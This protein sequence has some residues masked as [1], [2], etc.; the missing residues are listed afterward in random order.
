MKIRKS[1]A[2]LALAGSALFVATA[3]SSED[4]DEATSK[5]STAV[6]SAASEVSTAAGDAIDEVTGLSDSK[7]QDI[8]RKAVDPATPADEIDTVVDTSDPATKAAVIAFAKGSSAAGY[9]PEVYTVKD[10]S[11]DGDK[12][13]VATVSVASPHAPAPVDIKLTYVD[14]DGGW[15]LSA[16]AVTQL[17]GMAT[18][19]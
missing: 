11:K 13:A 7:A 8:L 4:V 15:K 19:H 16:D 14:A 3:C 12:Q 9:T 18:D 5:V 2:A 10:V 17:A 1:V 6:E